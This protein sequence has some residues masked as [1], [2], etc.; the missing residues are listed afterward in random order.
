M[1]DADGKAAPPDWRA[2]VD[3]RLVARCEDYTT[4]GERMVR[5]W[6]VASVLRPPKL[7][8]E[9]DDWGAGF[10][11]ADRERDIP[12]ALSTDLHENMPQALLRDLYRPE[13][14]ERFI[15]REIVEG[16]GRSAFPALREAREAQRKPPL[17]RIGSSLGAVR[18]YQT[19]RR[20]LLAECWKPVKDEPK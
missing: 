18:E 15:E 7:H 10:L 1:S 17:P 6:S 12:M 20:G 8:L 2:A 14:E 4:R 5:D 9:P 3:A 16:S 11:R 13:Y 19:W